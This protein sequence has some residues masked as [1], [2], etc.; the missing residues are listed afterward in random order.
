MRHEQD[1]GRIVQRE[2]YLRSKQ[3][4]R[5]AEAD[6]RLSVT[7]SP[8]REHSIVATNARDVMQA[9]GSIMI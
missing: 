2:E 8:P 5:E 1:Y 9:E 7:S 4:D 6:I 3:L